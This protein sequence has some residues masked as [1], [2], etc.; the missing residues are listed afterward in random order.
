VAQSGQESFDAF[1]RALPEPLR[2]EAAHAPAVADALVRALSS[3]RAAWPAFADDEALAAHLG[4]CIEPTDVLPAALE[5]LNAGDLCLALGC[6]RGAPD[7]IRAFEDATFGDLDRAWR[8]RTPLG[9][10]LDDT[11][12]VLRARLYVGGEETPPK[13]LSYSGR[14]TLRGFMRAVIARETINA[15]SR[16]KPEVPSDDALFAALPGTSEDAETTRLK[17]LYKPVLREAFVGAIA[18]LP[19]AEKN[20]LRYRYAENLSVQQVAAI[21]AI[22][23]ETAGLRIERARGALEAHIRAELVARLRLPEGEVSSV[24]RLALSGLDVTLARVF[25][26]H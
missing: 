24:V 18:R 14:G 3:A 11:K 25:G 20:L 22:H 19:P 15:F 13:I 7:A 4:R 9:T 17:A 23:R 8:G 16:A 10:E 2:A 1:V 6:A 26:T 5:Q 21:Y 12:Q